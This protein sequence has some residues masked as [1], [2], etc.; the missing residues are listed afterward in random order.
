MGLQGCDFR[1]GEAYA[2][3]AADGYREDDDRV[4]GI[5]GLAKRAVDIAASAA[6]LLFLLPVFLMI[7]LAIKLEGGPVFYR[8][9]RLGRKGKRFAML[10]FRTMRT[11]AE[12]VLE[13]L[14][15]RCPDS[16]SEWDT[17]QK[18]KRD[19]RITRTGDF[20]R[21]S[22]LDELP[23]L[24][25]ILKGDMSI[26]GQRPILPGQ[27]DAYGVHIAG[28]E[29]ARPGLTGLWQVS[30]RNQ[31]TFEERAAMGSEYISRWSLVFDLKIMLLTVPRVLLSRD[32]F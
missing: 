27:R 15:R 12:A 1:V 29:R 28:Y 22:S 20:L 11:D 3:P 21:R 32:A 25:N 19:P 23:Q 26:V 2:Y 7:A 14:L 31:L 30:G 16:K 4:F 13:D 6:A 17:F 5:N 9:T 24:L 8:Q 18:L 10:K